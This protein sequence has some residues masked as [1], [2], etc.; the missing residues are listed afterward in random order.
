MSAEKISASWIATSRACRP[1]RWRRTAR[2][3]SCRWPARACGAK[4]R[5][6]AV[7]APAG[8]RRARSQAREVVSA[9]SALRRRE[10]RDQLQR[11]GRR[12]STRACTCL[13]ARPSNR[14]ARVGV[15][16]QEGGGGGVVDAQAAQQRFGGVAGARD[17]RLRNSSKSCVGQRLE[18]R[19]QAAAARRA[20]VIMRCGN[21][22]ASG[23]IG[24]TPKAVIGEAG[25]QQ[26]TD[27]GQASCG[28]RCSASAAPCA[29]RTPRR[30]RADPTS[31]NVQS[32]R[33]CARVGRRHR[34]ATARARA[35]GC[36]P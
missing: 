31:S 30:A 20:S 13:P 4:R 16:A 19:R 29:A 27:G 5:D 24:A 2:C 25:Q 15:A 11:A 6:L 9:S 1:R 3:G 21:A 26:R 18:L 35:A 17:A 12:R 23:A 14:L 10:A 32:E 36:D 33:D 7:G 28:W 34:E 22:A 8:R